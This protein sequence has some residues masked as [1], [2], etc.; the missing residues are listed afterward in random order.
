MNSNFHHPDLNADRSENVKYD[1]EDFP[2]YLRRSPLSL[3]EDYRYDAHFHSDWE[4][5]VILSGDMDYNIDGEV[6]TIREGE[7]IFVN[8]GHIH[9]GF[10]EKKEECEYICMLVHPSLFCT[11]PYTERHYVLPL[12]QD[13]N[14]PYRLLSR[15][16]GIVGRILEI[17]NLRES[18]AADYLL[19]AQTCLF[20]IFE[21]LCAEK[22]KNSVLALPKRNF[23]E[24]KAM[25]E[26]ID[27]HYGEKISL[28]DIAKAAHVSKNSCILIFKQFVG[29]TPANYLMNYRLQKGVSLLENTDKTVTEI[30]YAVGFS[31]G[32]Y[33]AETFKAAFGYSPVKYKKEK[34]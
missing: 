14:L 34:C 27:G 15:E 9:F 7:G 33:F 25:L 3:C 31:G 26:F 11:N 20:G 8:S 2:I 30:A 10:S 23:S 5:I 4:F 24:M 16:D 22:K 21:D 32:S 6:V 29:S 28:G 18:A 19:K 12:M 13:M 17:N 1:F